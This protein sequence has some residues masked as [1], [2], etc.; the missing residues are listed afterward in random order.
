M[1]RRMVSMSNKDWAILF[2]I[3]LALWGSLIAV[4]QYN[5]QSPTQA[6][7]CLET[8]RCPSGS[9]P[10]WVRERVPQCICEA[11]SVPQ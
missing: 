3:M 4:V 8:A 1:L 7:T 9:T 11:G 2:A 6:D 5:K 10:T